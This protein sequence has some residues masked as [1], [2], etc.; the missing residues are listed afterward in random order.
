M[1][2]LWK[3]HKNLTCYYAQLFKE[4]ASVV[5]YNDF[6]NPQIENVISHFNFFFL[7]ASSH[8][9]IELCFFSFIGAVCAIDEKSPMT[10]D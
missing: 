8:L 2:S 4:G 5:F 1:I 10:H 7:D 3:Q 9:Y 6:M